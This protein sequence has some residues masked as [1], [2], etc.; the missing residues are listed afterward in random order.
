MAIH[1]IALLRD[2]PLLEMQRGALG[3]LGDLRG[4]ERTGVNGGSEGHGGHWAGMHWKEGVAEWGKDSLGQPAYGPAAFSVAATASFTALVTDSNR[5]QPPS[6]ASL[7]PTLRCK[8]APSANS[9]GTWS[10]A[11]SVGTCA[12]GI[13]LAGGTA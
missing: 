13:A 8:H 3:I 4:M 6:N 1:Q 12:A 5:P 9:Q 10:W 7:G 11:P 2:M